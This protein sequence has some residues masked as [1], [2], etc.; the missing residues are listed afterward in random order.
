MAV[1]VT[2]TAMGKMLSF[3]D[4]TSRTYNI[5]IVWHGIANPELVVGFIESMVERAKSNDAGLEMDAMQAALDRQIDGVENE[6]DDLPAT[7][8]VSASSDL[9]PITFRKHWVILFRKTWFPFV[10]GFAGLYYP[11]G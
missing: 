8:R 3:G 10:F 11:G 6:S 5:P 9:H 7:G 4:I 1:E 2:T